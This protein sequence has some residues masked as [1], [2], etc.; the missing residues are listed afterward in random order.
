MESLGVGEYIASLLWMG[1]VWN[2][3]AK[4]YLFE[5]IMPDTGYR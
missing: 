4:I 1:M 5:R 3:L 2:G